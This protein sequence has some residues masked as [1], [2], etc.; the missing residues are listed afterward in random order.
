MSVIRIYSS[1]KKSKKQKFKSSEAAKQ[2]RELAESWDKLKS[3]WN[4]V[5]TKKTST[6]VITSMPNAPKVYVREQQEIKSLNSW[7]TGAVS[8][9]PSQQYTGTNMVGISTLHKSNA[10]PV[11]SQQEAIEISKM[12]R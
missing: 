11:F 8:S 2:A 3:K 1:S 12:R 5:S 9:K 4:N 7:T 10:V 6:I